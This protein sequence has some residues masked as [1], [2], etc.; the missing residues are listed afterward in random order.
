MGGE[1]QGCDRRR[2][3]TFARERSAAG[4]AATGWAMGMG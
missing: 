2:G 1:C 3:R 4:D